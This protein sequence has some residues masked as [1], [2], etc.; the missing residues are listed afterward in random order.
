MRRLGEDFFYQLAMH[1]RQSIVTALE[2]VGEPRVVD[3]QQMQRGGVEIV[4]MHGV[5]DDVVAEFIR[6]AEHLAALHSG[7]CH[8]D[9]ETARVM[10]ASVSVMGKFAL[11]IHGAA[12]LAAPD[13]E[14]V[15]E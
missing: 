5:F 12:K 11:R 14:R 2:T 10:V 1:I 4:D 8:P 15:V 9:A 7:T 3:A 6:L 13:D